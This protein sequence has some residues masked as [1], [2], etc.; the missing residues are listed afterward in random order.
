MSDVLILGAGLMQKPAIQAAKKLG[1][2]VTVVDAN[3]AAVCVPFADRFEPVDLKD[4]DSL[5]SLA[6]ELKNSSGLSA[7]FTAGTD[8]SASV[9]YLTEKLGLPGHTYRAALNASDKIR[10]RS[11][12]QKCGVPSP[13]FMEITKEDFYRSPKELFEVAGFSDYPLVV[14]PVDNLGARGCIL[15]R[16]ET[17]LLPA[18]KDAVKYSRSGRAV[19]EEYIDGPEFSIDSLIFDGELTITGFADRHIYYPPYFIETGH[20]MPTSVNPENWNRLAKTFF[21][22][23]KSL[24]LTHGACKADIKL[25]KNGPVIGEIAARLSG[26]YMSGW[27]FPYSSGVDLTEQALLLALGRE[28]EE[29]LEKRIKTGVNGIWN[30]P[31]KRFSA[32]RAWISIPGT[33]SC[34]HGLEESERNTFVENILPRANPGDDVSFPVNNVEKCGNV[35]SCAETR[36]DAVESAESKVAEIVLELACPDKRTESFLLSTYETH[37]PPSAFIV[38]MKVY[39]DTLDHFCDMMLPPGADL[40]EYMPECLLP[41]ADSV[42]DWN[43][44]TIRQT[45]EIFMMLRPDYAVKNPV[46]F[47]KT[48]FRGGI[49]GLLY[50]TSQNQR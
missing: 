28:P 18:L 39:M 43:K 23:I 11:C 33:I 16:K 1:Y 22:G 20:T 32:E 46:L 24:G 26:G 25:S 4:K 9:S 21:D 36:I 12:F 31:S 44:R 34:I 10:M 7:A 3:P 40:T 38:P 45:L 6:A 50:M 48:L 17:E 5:L 30:L 2:H 13:L 8:F 29:L 27:T 37:F 41:Y 14:K 35:I 49:Q 19:L 15:I 42:V 47:Y